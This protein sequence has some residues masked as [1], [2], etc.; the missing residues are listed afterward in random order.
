ME[1]QIDTNGVAG[2][3]VHSALAL[4]GTGAA[5][6]AQQGFV[7]DGQTQ[8]VEF[9]PCPTLGA[10][11]VGQVGS[12]IAS[13]AFGLLN[14]G[15]YLINNWPY[16]TAGDL[17]GFVNFTGFTEHC[18]Y[19]GIQQAGGSLLV[20]WIYQTQQAPSGGNNTTLVAYP[21]GVQPPENCSFFG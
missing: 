9:Y 21:A 1:V 7:P 19:W 2:I 8:T 6:T 11:S 14:S 4:F 13:V 12:P 10:C 18:G 17:Y 20:L 3:A 5:L 16:A 15:N